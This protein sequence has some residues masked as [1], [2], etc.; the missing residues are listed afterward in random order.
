MIEAKLGILSVS[1]SLRVLGLLAH[2]RATS[3]AI[4]VPKSMKV[5]SIILLVSY[6]TDRMW[7]SVQDC[8]NYLMYDL[9]VL[10]EAASH[11]QDRT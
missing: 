1:Y 2:Q 7:E 5:Y 3:R 6:S 10:G 9:P 8:E 11:I 4:M